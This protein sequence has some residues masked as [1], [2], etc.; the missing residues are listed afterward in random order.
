V[1]FHLSGLARRWAGHYWKILKIGY[2]RI[3]TDF[4][5]VLRTVVMLE[6]YRTAT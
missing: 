3:M 5:D 4:P 6:I 2:H 1:A